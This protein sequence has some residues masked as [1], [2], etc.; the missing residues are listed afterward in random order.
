MCV[1]K[2]SHRLSEKALSGMVGKSCVR[3]GE[4]TSRGHGWEWNPLRRVMRG[5]ERQELRTM[6][7][8]LCWPDG[9]SWCPLICRMAEK[10]RYLGARVREAGAD[11]KE[12]R[13]KR[14]SMC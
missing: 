13:L 2:G 1:L 3:P 4:G 8:S 14:F 12:G 10:G 6:T 7:R 11:R 9:P 5:Q